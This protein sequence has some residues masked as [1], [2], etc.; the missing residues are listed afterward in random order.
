MRKVE[1]I[2]A[3]YKLGNTNLKGRCSFQERGS[4]ISKEREQHPCQDRAGEKVWCA[5]TNQ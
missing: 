5:G 4:G 1:R 3:G 2:V